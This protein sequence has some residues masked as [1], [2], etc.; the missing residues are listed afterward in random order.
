MPVVGICSGKGGVG[1]TTV[2]ANLSAMLTY[3][4]SVVVVDGDIALPNLHAL[5]GF[6]PSITLLDV[7]TGNANVKDAIYR[8]KVGESSL[9]IVPSSQ[10]SSDIKNLDSF[11]EVLNELGKVYDFVIVDVAAGLSKYAIVPMMGCEKIYIVLNPEETSIMDAQ[12]VKKVVDSINADF[13]GVII[14][15]YRGER[16]AVAMAEKRVGSV[17]GII[18]DSKAIRKGWEKG[19]VVTAVKP[20]AKVSEEFYTLARRVAGENVHPRPYGKLRYILRL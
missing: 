4:G 9:D 5:F 14:N 18:R 13:E 15:R 16:W 12:R 3:F 17:A 11:V 2:S 19:Y 20:E 7:L 6:E 1:K 10:T 8:I